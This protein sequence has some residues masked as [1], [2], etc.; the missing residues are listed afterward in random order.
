M[1][2]LAGGDAASSAT[3]VADDCAGVAVLADRVEPR[4][5]P[6]K[7]FSGPLEVVIHFAGAGMGQ[8]GELDE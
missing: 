3:G 8:W 7:G 5:F 4:A 1:V 6:E 2:F